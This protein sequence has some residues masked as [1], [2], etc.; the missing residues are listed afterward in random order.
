MLDELK[1][2]FGLL[3]SS[4][5]EVGVVLGA[6]ACADAFGDAFAQEDDLG[7]VAGVVIAGKLVAKVVELEVEA[8]GEQD[9]VLD[10]FGD[11]GEE[12]THG[13]RGA[14]LALG[15]AGEQAA[16]VLELGA[17]ADGGEDV[18]DLALVLGGVADAVGGEHGQAQ[19]F[20]E[21]ESGLIAPFFV[22]FAVALQFDVHV[23]G[24]KSRMKFS[25]SARAAGSPPRAR[26]A[27][28]GPSSP[29]VRQMR[30][31]ANSAMSSRLAVPSALPRSRILK[32][33]MSWQRL[34]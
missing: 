14:D 11:V 12:V 22:A 20:G 32:R 16:G 30:P 9:G 18:E 4:G 8:L 25:S 28:S 1:L 6:V 33:V 27:A 17:V 7:F 31:G 26:A 13:A 23:A 2:A 5:E 34:A 29:P 15:V 24:P 3:F 10:G 21:A 19:G